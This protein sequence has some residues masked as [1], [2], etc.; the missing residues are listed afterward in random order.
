MGDQVLEYLELPPHQRDA[1]LTDDGATGRQID[2]HGIGRQQAV[3]AS[4]AAAVE[5]AQSRHQF[6]DVGRHGHRVVRSGIQRCTHVIAFAQQG[7]H[8]HVRQL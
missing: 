4:D 6:V 7:D 5:C 8:R 3:G 1:L 2:G